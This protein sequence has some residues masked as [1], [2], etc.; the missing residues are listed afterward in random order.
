MN[1]SVEETANAGSLSGEAVTEMNVAGL[2][3]GDG[4]LLLGEH[5]VVKNGILTQSNCDPVLIGLRDAK[6]EQGVITN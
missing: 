3:N 5:F 1:H 4:Q 6:L 2:G